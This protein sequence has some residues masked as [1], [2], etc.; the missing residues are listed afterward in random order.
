MGRWPSSEGL[1]PMGYWPSSEGLA[2]WGAGLAV[3]A[4][5]YG[6]LA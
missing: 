6:V 5:A 3:R 2:L 4:S 1:R